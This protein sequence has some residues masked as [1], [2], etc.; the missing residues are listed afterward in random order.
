MDMKEIKVRIFKKYGSQKELAKKIG[1]TNS[2]VSNYL[3]GVRPMNINFMN[4]LIDA[5]DISKEEIGNIF[6]S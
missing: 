6:F 4:K 3:T 5:L 1:V 2:T